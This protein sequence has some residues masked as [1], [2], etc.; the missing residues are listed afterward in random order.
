M[1]H[2]RKL[3]A[4]LPALSL[5]SKERK[6]M[7]L[8]SNCPKSPIPTNTTCPR[9]RQRLPAAVRTGLHVCMQAEGWQKVR[10]GAQGRGMPPV[11]VSTVCPCL[12]HCLC[13]PSHT[14][15]KV[16][17]K[18]TAHPPLF[19]KRHGERERKCWGPSVCRKA[20][21]SAQVQALC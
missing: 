20:E 1:L 14:Q 9:H 16:R 4:L 21:K 19:P 12:S 13:R 5:N 8:L 3:K 7:A 10:R 11:P 2:K 6:G 17:S 15:A 18:R